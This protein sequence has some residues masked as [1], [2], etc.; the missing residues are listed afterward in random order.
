MKYFYYNSKSGYNDAFK[1]WRMNFIRDNFTLFAVI[2][3]VLLIAIYVFSS[4]KNKR[5]LKKRA[6]QER[7]FKEKNKGKEDV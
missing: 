7:I 1:S 2:I 6:E 4:W 3:I 5:R